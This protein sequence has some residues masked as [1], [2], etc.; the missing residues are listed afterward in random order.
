M[1]KATELFCLLDDLCQEFEALLETR[2]LTYCSAEEDTGKRQRNRPCVRSLFEMSIMGVLFYRMPARQF[3][4]FY[5]DIVCRFMKAEFPQ[6]LSCNCFV[7]LKPR[8]GAVLAAFSK[9]SR[10]P[11]RVCPLPNRP[12]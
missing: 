6:R 3:K 4:A 1:D 5:C 10:A 2:V 8:C 7:Q 11:E 9:R 12:R